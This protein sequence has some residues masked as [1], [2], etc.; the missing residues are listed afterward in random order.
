MK[1]ESLLLSLV[2]LAAGCSSLPREGR[3]FLD[4]TTHSDNAPSWVKQTKVSW[5][6]KDKVFIRSSHSVRGNERVN[7]CFDL[8][9]LDSKESILSEIANDVR[10]TLD[11]AQQSISEDAEVVLGKV[12]SS[13]FSGRITGLRFSEQ[14]YERY[15]V[16]DTER[17]DCHVLGEIKN[18][19]YSRIKRAV[20]DR[21]TSVDPQLKEAITRKHVDFFAPKQPASFEAAQRET[22]TDTDK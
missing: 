18:A 12:R 2:L 11:N 19:D 14:Y 7:G 22:A 4:S 21:I 6:E 15:F 20:V 5:E 1:Y 8:A 17:V 13:E 3:V 16:G 10:G 9:R